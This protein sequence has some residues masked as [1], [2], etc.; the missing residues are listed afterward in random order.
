MTKTKLNSSLISD[1]SFE[2]GVLTINFTNGRDV[3][4]QNVPVDVVSQL[5]NSDS[6]GRF[7]NS[8]IR[9]KYSH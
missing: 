3:T 7:Y 1:V 6:P 4:Y 9:S 8:K 5:I 2:N